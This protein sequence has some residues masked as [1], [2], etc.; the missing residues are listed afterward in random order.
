MI[1][2][3]FVT[4]LVAVMALG[5]LVIGCGGEDDPII[6]EQNARIRVIHASHDGPA[7]DVAVD[8]AKVISDL[9]FGKS[10]GFAEVAAGLRQITV[11]T[12]NTTLIDKTVT[13]VPGQDYSVYALNEAKALESVVSND[14]RAPNAA[15]AKVR[16]VHASPDAPAVDIRLNSGDGPKVFSNIAFKKVTDYLE[17]DAGSYNFVVTAAGKTDAVVTY[18]PATLEEGQVYTVM[19]IGTLAAGDMYPFLVRVFVD[20][21][22]GAAS[23]DLKEKKVETKPMA[24]VMVVHGSPDAPAVD[25]LV[26]GTKV[27]SAGLAFPKNTGYL[28]LEAGKEFNI[29]VN[30]AGTSTTAIEADLSFEKDKAYTVFAAGKVAEIAPLLL[31][32]DLTAPAAGKAHVRFVHLSPDAPAVDIAVKSGP[33]VFEKVA[34][35][36]FSAF[37]PVDAGTLDLEVLVSSSGTKALDV[38]GVKLEAG[39]IYTIWAKGLLADGSLGAEIIVNK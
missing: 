10:S 18:D 21:Q 5:V 14:S 12:G 38:S 39:K 30:V 8:G 36:G 17:V 26:D 9:A 34:F 22:N 11:T 19:A 24:K 1:K 20:T 23:V 6:S 4:S 16:F 3:S 7:V 28:E 27:N 13:L 33:K 31:T 37:T 32:D 35:K 15:K 29:K 2:K 25:L